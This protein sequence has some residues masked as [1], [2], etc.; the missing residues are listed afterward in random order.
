MTYKLSLL[1]ICI[2]NIYIKFIIK[3]TSS[4]LFTLRRI[5][6]TFHLYCRFFLTSQ[7]EPDEKLFLI[8][9]HAECTLG[10]GNEIKREEE[11]KKHKRHLC[12]NIFTR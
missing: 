3:F 9:S 10:M 2:G 5:N 12:K 11:D 7:E 1:V 6:E 4:H 8:Y